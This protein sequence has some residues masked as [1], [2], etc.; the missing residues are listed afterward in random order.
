MYKAVTT[1]K[2][3]L[4]STDL[5]PVQVKKVFHLVQLILLQKRKDQ[6]FYIKS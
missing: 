2:L 3:N 4:K 5:Y 6:H 1:Y